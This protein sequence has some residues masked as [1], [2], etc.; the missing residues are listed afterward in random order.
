MT[1][2]RVSIQQPSSTG[3]GDRGAS[4]A[5]NEIRLSPRGWLVV[6][7]LVAAVFH[8]TPAAWERLEPLDS[9]DDYRV[10]FRLSHDYWTVRRYCRDIA[11]GDKTIVLGDSVIWGHYVG[12]QQALPHYL[13]R[14]SGRDQFINLGVD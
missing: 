10:P 8:L 12:P 7:I 11:A 3:A 4:F 2:R 13:N 14:L 9:K 5:S 1:V 6:L